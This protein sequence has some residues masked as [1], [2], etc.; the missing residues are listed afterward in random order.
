MDDSYKARRK[1]RVI[2]HIM[3]D[4]SYDVIKKHLPKEWVIRPFNQPDYGIDLVI[5]LFDKIDERYSE[6]LGEFIY[7][8]VKSVT[9]LEET[10]EKIYPVG[11]VAKAEWRENRSEH[12]EIPVIKYPFDTNSIYTIQ[13]WGASVSVLLLV[14]NITTEDAYFICMNDYIDKLLLP[15]TPD[16]EKQASVTVTIPAYNNL[17]DKE[18]TQAAFGFYGK[19]AKLL[20]AFSKFFYQKNEIAHI[21][22]FKTWPVHTYR[23]QLEHARADTDGS[24]IDGKTIDDIL[25]LFINQIEYLDIWEYSAWKPLADSKAELLALKSNLLHPKPDEKAEVLFGEILM[26]WH[27]LTNLASMYEEICREWYLPKM[28]SLLCSYPTSPDIKKS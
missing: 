15:K 28:L 17:K 16:Y 5:E 10:P 20:A 25:L 9:D 13:T 24:T 12:I 23:E 22:Q 19:R 1:R 14:V 7:V 4:G 21:F 2:Q 6:T 26:T 27:H 8:Q 3:E 11:N 18:V